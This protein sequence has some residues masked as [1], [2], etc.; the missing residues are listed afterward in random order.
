MKLFPDT[1]HSYFITLDLPIKL[2]HWCRIDRMTLVSLLLV[3]TVLAI[4]TSHAAFQTLGQCQGKTYADRCTGPSGQHGVCVH[5]W[6]SKGRE[7]LCLAPNKHNFQFRIEA[8]YSSMSIKSRGGPPVTK[9][10]IRGSGPGLSWSK[11]VE[12]RKPATSL[13][14]WT[15]D[16]QYTSGLVG[17]GC[18]SS[19]R[20][21]FNQRA[22]EFR[23]Y[24]DR[25]ANEE[26]EGPNFY[27]QLPLSDSMKDSRLYITP[28]TTVYPWFNTKKCLVQTFEYTLRSRFLEIEIQIQATLVYPPSYRENVLKKYPIVVMFDN[29]GKHYIP[30]LEYLFVHTGL[31]EEALVVVVS[32]DTLLKNTVHGNYSMLPFDS[33]SL[34]CKSDDCT[35][36]QVCWKENRTRQCQTDEFRLRSKQ[37]L[38]FKHNRGTSEDL[39]TEII[40]SLIRK[41]QEATDKRAKFDTPRER[42]TLVGHSETAVAVFWIG[43]LRPDL[44]A[45]V[46]AISPKFH[47]PLTSDYKL[48]RKILKKM[49][50]L[51]LKFNEHGGQQLLYSTQKYYFSQGEKDDLKFPFVNVKS[52]TLG[53]IRKLKHK[54]RMEDR[55]N[56]MFRITPG[57][58]V[59]Y[60]T[61]S[62]QLLPL[63]SHIKPFM[64]YFHKTDGGTSKKKALN[65]QS[66]RDYIIES[67]KALLPAAKDSTPKT[68][69]TFIEITYREGINGEIEII[70]CGEQSHKEVPLVVFLGFIGMPHDLIMM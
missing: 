42:I 37:C 8:K 69:G 11:S 60:P 14:T 13:S 17:M 26:M 52:T 59:V 30:Q 66:F 19:Q 68:N 25:D 64:M 39:L 70:R 33:Y 22:F 61:S 34:E 50:D 27:I 32:P 24:R 4:H 36:C 10:F 46:A 48:E 43:L 56:I 23:I 3:A 12:M 38:Y 47:L 18:T 16:F 67:Q 15:A 57:E 54:F 21:S 63:V 7:L 35:R 31:V 51:A 6:T 49:D 28:K 40:T 20:C 41:V 29:Y 44:V 55:Q 65:V 9:M 53:V 45:N 1:I 58:S 2:V 5:I 62:K